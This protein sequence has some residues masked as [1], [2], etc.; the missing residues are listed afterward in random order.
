MT[1][2]ERLAAALRAAAPPAT[3]T[4]AGRD[5]VLAEAT[6]RRHRRL[7]TGAALGVAASLAVALGA[8]ALLRD[9]DGPTSEVRTVPAGPTPSEGAPRTTLAPQPGTTTATTA[10]PK[11]P[12][13][14]LAVTTKGA[15]LVV[16][17]A[18][19][20]V[21]RTLA[22]PG[23]A[24]PNH[25]PARAL[26]SDTVYFAKPSV[27]CGYPTLFEVPFDGSRAPKR[28]G[29]G[30]KPAVS[31]DG[32]RLAYETA[33]NGCMGVTLVVRDLV[34]GKERRW[35][36]PRDDGYFGIGA[37]TA[38]AWA[39]DARRLAFQF[40]NEGSGVYV[41]DTAVPGTL[42]VALPVRPSQQPRN[43]SLA[44]LDWHPAGNRI[45]VSALCCL[46]PD[47]MTQEQVRTT[48]RTFLVDTTTMQ[49]E[50][51]YEPGEAASFLDYD[52]SGRFTVW[53]AGDRAASLRLRSPDGTV[54]SI[55]SGLA[56]AAW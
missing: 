54:R 6:A 11:A 16:D 10:A 56:A 18:T 14:A 21:V 5:A 39:P 46:D 53:A 47:G 30:G 41:L 31:P 35:E 49:A 27:D 25:K 44:L 33:S 4:A 17:T 13:T 51:L 29:N 43:T 37:I 2:E 42:Q 3:N 36:A 9:D 52:D 48:T 20:D 7:R 34:A 50:P 12:D 19:G 45:A 1:T 28:L 8:I 23:S 24:D 26:G 38:I 40:E 55:G 32:S 15:L 22:P